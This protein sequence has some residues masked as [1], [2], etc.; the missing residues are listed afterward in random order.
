MTEPLRHHR[1]P[2]IGFHGGWWT[3]NLKHVTQHQLTDRTSPRSWTTERQKHCTYK[4]HI[5]LF[6]EAGDRGVWSLGSDLIL[7]DR[8]PSLPTLEAPNIQ[9]IQEETSILVPTV[10]ESW[11]EEEEG[12]TLILM[13]RIPSEPLSKAWP[14]LSTDEKQN[15]VRQTA[16]YLLQLRKLQSEKMQAPSGRPIYSNFLFLDN[17]VSGRT[18]G[19]LLSDNEL[20][21]EMEPARIQLRNHMP[22]APLCTFTH[23]DLTHVNIMVENGSLTSIIDWELAGYYLVWWEYVCTSF[24]D[25]EEDREWKTLLRRY[26]PDYSAAGN[27]VRFMESL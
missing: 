19:P 5:K 24:S 18:H 25:S 16:E 2:L 22:P 15:I 6:Y 13:K 27:S 1:S 23:S 12:H 11:E 21:T 3:W 8:G 26:M 10:V 17:K 14:K 7:K 4:S 9:F 20:W